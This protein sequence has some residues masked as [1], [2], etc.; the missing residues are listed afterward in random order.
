MNEILDRGKRDYQFTLE[1]KEGVNLNDCLQNLRNLFEIKFGK[2]DIFSN[3]EITEKA[4]RKVVEG[5]FKANGKIE[6]RMHLFLRNHKCCESPIF[7]SK[8]IRTGP[9]KINR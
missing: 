2:D 8:I 4:N 5:D 1:F 3:W 9:R 7:K 6:H